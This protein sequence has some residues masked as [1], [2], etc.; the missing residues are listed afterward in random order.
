MSCRHVDFFAVFAIT[1][2][3]LAASEVRNALP[4]PAG[5]IR[6]QNGIVSIHARPLAGQI[7][8]RLVHFWSL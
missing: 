4:D 3:L 5:P 1:L 2:G 6:I 8:Y 7:L